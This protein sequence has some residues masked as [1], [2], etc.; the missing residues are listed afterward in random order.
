M[1]REQLIAS[2]IIHG[3]DTCQFL[4]TDDTAQWGIH[5]G[6]TLLEVNYGVARNLSDSYVERGEGMWEMF[7]TD[8]LQLLHMRATT[9]YKGARWTGN[10]RLPR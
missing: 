5:K 10:N 1:D 2:L 4:D 9:F 7:S 3:W 8:Q 6:D